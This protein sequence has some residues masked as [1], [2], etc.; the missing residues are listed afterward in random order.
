MENNRQV[1]NLTNDTLALLKKA[2]FLAMLTE[3]L[4][5]KS[6]LNK[7]NL[8]NKLNDVEMIW[9]LNNDDPVLSEIMKKENKPRDTLCKDMIMK[10]ITDSA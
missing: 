7:T 10:A 9:N 2:T 4:C 1:S 3:C 5:E 6:N 8:C